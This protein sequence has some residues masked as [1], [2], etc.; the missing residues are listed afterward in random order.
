MAKN[1]LNTRAL[2]STIALPLVVLTA[3]PA[4]ILWWTGS[5]KPGWGL[6]GWSVLFSYLFGMLLT[7]VGLT[8]LVSTIRLFHDVGKGTLAPWD[9]PKHLVIEGPY[10]YVRNPMHSGVF[11]TLYGEG[12]LFGSVPVLLFVTAVFIFHWFYIPLMEER[13]LSEKFGE[14]YQDY[15]RNVPP[16]IPRL[17]PWKNTNE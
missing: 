1:Q 6:S 11:I 15:K 9:P 13:W 12:L 16:W 10:R 14:K 7:S 8:L 17:R 2:R 5:F 3:I 4:L